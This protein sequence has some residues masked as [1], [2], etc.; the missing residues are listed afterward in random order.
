V[1]YEEGG[2]RHRY[3]EER[4]TFLL[5]FLVIDIVLECVTESL[6]EIEVTLPPTLCD[7]E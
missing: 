7:V 3:V 2:G 5:G 1:N 4:T 6:L